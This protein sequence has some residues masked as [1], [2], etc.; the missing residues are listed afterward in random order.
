MVIDKP[1][2]IAENI[3]EKQE[4]SYDEALNLASQLHRGRQLEPAERLYRAL[5][6]IQPG[7]PNVMH[8]LGVL[9]YQAQRREEGVEW[10]RRSLEIDPNVA[11]WHNNLGNVMLDAGHFDDA[12][13]CYA[14]CSELDPHNIEVLNNLGVMQRSLG[15][16]DQAEQTLLRAVALKPEF[17][18]ARHNLAALYFSLKRFTEGFTHSA[19]A[20]AQEPR[21]TGTRRVLGLVYGHLGRHEEAAQIYREWLEME[22]DSEQARHYL[23]GCTGEDVP[24]RAAQTYVEKLFDSFAA[25]FDAKLEALDYRAPALVGEAVAAALGRGEGALDVLDAGCGTG[26]C[27]PWL[28][29]YARCLVG[30]DLSQAMLDKA[31]ERSLYHALVKDD[32]VLHLHKNPAGYELIVSADTLC[33][34]GRLDE[35]L[36]AAAAA[37]RD[38]GALFFTAETHDDVARSFWLHPHGRYSHHRAYIE[39]TLRGAGFAEPQFEAVVLRHECGAPVSGWLVSARMAAR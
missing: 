14:R 35:V 9:L 18:D 3:A 26:L 7:D 16:A 27:G 13:R 28:A 2:E 39:S 4:M 11:S 15:H 34:F 5:L 22:P 21:H 37:L 19:Q 30:V 1:Q 25:S 23:A 10:I 8:Y 24:E 38:G 29:P 31:A 32:L 17:T 20:L 33:Y 36:A 12:S 6:G